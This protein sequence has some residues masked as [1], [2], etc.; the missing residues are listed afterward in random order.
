MKK[1]GLYIRVSTDE[2]AKIQEGSLVSQKQRLEEYLKAR[3]LVQAGWG[4][5]CGVYIDDKSAKD[6][7]RPQFQVMLKDIERK[8]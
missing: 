3:N 6:T 8:K 4:E 7:N 1:V 5:I 2:Q